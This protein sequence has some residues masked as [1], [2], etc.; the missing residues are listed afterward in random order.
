MTDTLKLIAA[1]RYHLGVIES[2]TNSG[3]LIDGW[4]R[5]AGATPGNPWCAAFA[6][7]CLKQSGFAGKVANAA[8]CAGLVA[9]G[10]RYNKVVA[11]PKPGDLAVFDWSDTVSPYDHVGIIERVVTFGPICTLQ[12][13]E[14]N[15]SEHGKRDGVYRR[16]RVVRRS[17]VVFLRF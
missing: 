14:G 6:Y 11:I 4:L 12:T 8:S 7:S 10:K 9:Y 2:S 5:T 13:I 16:R 3:P 1:A 17:S 15:T